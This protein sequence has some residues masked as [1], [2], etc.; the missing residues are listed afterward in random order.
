MQAVVDCEGTVAEVA[1]YR[2]FAA[3][4]LAQRARCAAAIRFLPAADIVRVGR[5]VLFRADLFPVEPV[6]S[7]KRST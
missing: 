1:Y 7:N 4:I 2:F 5:A 3:L 6:P